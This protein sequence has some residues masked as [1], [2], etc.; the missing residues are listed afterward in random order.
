ML[1]SLWAGRVRSAKFGMLRVTII[2]EP[3]A[4][5]KHFIIARQVLSTL[6]VLF[7]LIQQSYDVEIIIFA[8]QVKH[9]SLLDLGKVINF[10]S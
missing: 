5:I 6:H 2:I 7:E 1:V 10:S 9:L 4:D 3:E 8:F